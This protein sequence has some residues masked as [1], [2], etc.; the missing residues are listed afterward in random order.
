MKNQHL[1][2]TDISSLR[3]E[4]FAI[5]KLRAVTTKLKY[6]LTD[7]YIFLTLS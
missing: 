4:S 1:H 5:T 2:L 3:I 7:S 6:N